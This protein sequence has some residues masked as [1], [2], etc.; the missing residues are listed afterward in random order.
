MT[1]FELKESSAC[2]SLQMYARAL[3]VGQ[4]ELAE[5]LP[6]ALTT[7]MAATEESWERLLQE[8]PTEI[9]PVFREA[10][11][12]Y[13]VP[14]DFMPA[15]HE[16]MTDTRRERDVQARKEELRPRW[17]RLLGTIRSASGINS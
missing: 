4:I 1:F 15:P 6:N 2:R 8:I 16:F 5:Y 9:F 13:L 7:I 14:V 12:Q 11:E 17:V 10:A 3:K